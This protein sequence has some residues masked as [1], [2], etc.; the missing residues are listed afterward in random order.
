MRKNCAKAM[1][2]IAALAV[3][4]AITWRTVKSYHERQHLL[5]HGDIRELHSVWANRDGCRVR[6]SVSTAA[7]KAQYRSF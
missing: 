5:Q 7:A 4:A 6:A 1:A 3:G 2:P